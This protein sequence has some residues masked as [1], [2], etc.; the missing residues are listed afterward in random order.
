MGETRWGSLSWRPSSLRKG[1]TREDKGLTSEKGLDGQFVTM[2]PSS[3]MRSRAEEERPS[4]TRR[5]NRCHLL[6]PPGSSSSH[7]P[8]TGSRVRW[9][10]NAETRC[11]PSVAGM[12]FS[13]KEEWNSDPGDSAP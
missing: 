10:M 11:G 2:Y 7:K 4:P 5:R 12:L 9:R 8:V 3:A 1:F 6:P 13:L